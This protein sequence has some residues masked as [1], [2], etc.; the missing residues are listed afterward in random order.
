LVDENVRIRRDLTRA[1][2][3]V[4]VA[5]CTG[6]QG[7]KRLLVSLAFV[8]REGDIIAVKFDKYRP[9]LPIRTLRAILL[10][11]TDESNKLVFEARSN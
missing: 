2:D 5:F 7:L 3:D 9:Q 1:L 8:G 6:T 11:H 4:M 10:K